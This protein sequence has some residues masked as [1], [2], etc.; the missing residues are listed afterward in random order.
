MKHV[1]LFLAGSNFNEPEPFQNLI[2]YVTG[3]ISWLKPWLYHFFPILFALAVK[4]KSLDSDLVV[5][6]RCL[7]VGRKK[8]QGGSASVEALA[9]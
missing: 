7:A 3:N 6:W 8:H 9:K 2:Q 4:L 5:G 1:W